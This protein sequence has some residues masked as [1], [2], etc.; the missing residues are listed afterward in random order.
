EESLVEHPAEPR[1]AVV[2]ARADH[3]DVRLVRSVRADEADEETHDPVVILRDP[4][5][6]G[7]VLEPQP[8]QEQV[9]PAT[10]PPVIDAVDEDTVIGLDRTA[11]ANVAAHRAATQATTAPTTSSTMTSGPNTSSR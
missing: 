7:E 5:R 3:V 4:G 1:A 2:R 6:P 11:Q 8:G 9:H 10:T